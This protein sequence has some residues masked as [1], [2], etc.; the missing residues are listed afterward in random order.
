M[1]PFFF[2]V[3]IMPIE[4]EKIQS[5]KPADFVQ[6]ANQLL[7]Q[8]RFASAS[9]VMGQA[10]AKYPDELGLFPLTLRCLIYLGEHQSVRAL[11]KDYEQRAGGQPQ[12][13]G[14]C[15][16][17][18]AQCQMPE[19]AIHLYRQL[20]SR[21]NRDAQYNLGANL[22]SIGALTEAEEV[23]EE[24]IAK[25]PGD[26]QA[27]QVLSGVR[28]VG[29]DDNHIERLLAML[30][31]PDLSP[32]DR[33]Q[34]HYALGKEH[35]DIGEY[36]EAFAQFK[37]GADLR[38]SVLGYQVQT[39]VQ[40]LAQIE[41]HHG[42]LTSASLQTSRGQQAIFVFGLPRSGTTLV[43]RILSSHSECDS[44]GEITDLSLSL[45]VTAGRSL[46]K[47]ELVRQTVQWAPEKIANGYLQR[48]ENYGS[49]AAKHIDKTPLNFLYAGL[50]ARAI[51]AATMIWMD[52][53]PLDACFAMYKT[54]FKM[55]Y[56]FSY[57][58]DDLAQYYIA[59][60][61]LKSRWRESIGDAIRFQ[62]YEKLVED[63]DAQSRS[64]VNAAGLDWEDSCGEFHKNRS[65]VTTASSAQVRRP[66]Y[67]SAL[68]HWKNYQEEL[69]P[70][71]EKLEKTGIL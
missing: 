63:F 42:Q 71:A 51:P 21:G 11:L 68:G 59:Y 16:E 27:H 65:A 31:N 67:K 52:R 36:A 62:S 58:L 38:R 35:E 45:M 9:E 20:A 15:A 24:L 55:G 6:L 54:L 28:K 53:H 39:D 22:I 17:L 49:T 8:G 18:F 70:L 29:A 43:D 47:E 25:H 64:L 12:H 10:R 23:L 44:F 32:M 61:R 46:P 69:A 34:I 5:H 26:G 33:I 37:S 13:L 19:K 48:L 1:R 56:P 2:G 50:I 57:S 41:R 40:T 30:T 7:Q 3:Q 14:Q 60:D 66:L 4:P